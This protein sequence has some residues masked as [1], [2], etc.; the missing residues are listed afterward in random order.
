MI[1]RF[2]L[3]G[4][5]VAL[6]FFGYLHSEVGCEGFASE[7]KCSVLCNIWLKRQDRETGLAI[8]FDG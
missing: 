5:G 6:I 7:G 3:R 8:Q 4:H 1:T 2:V